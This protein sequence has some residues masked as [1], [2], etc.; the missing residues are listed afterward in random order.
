MNNLFPERRGINFL[1][2]LR[3]L[4][5][6][7]ILLGI[8]AARESSTHKI[9]IYLDGDIGSGHLA[10]LHLR[11]NEILRIGMFDGN[12]EHKRTSATILRY[13]TG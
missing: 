1:S 4:A 8:I 11:I 13:L 9:I 7:G 6:N 2:H 5:I 3:L 10:L 12:G